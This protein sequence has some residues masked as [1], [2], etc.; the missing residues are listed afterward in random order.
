MPAVL[1]N[2][3]TTATLNIITWYCVFAVFRRGTCVEKVAYMPKDINMVVPA[4][5]EILQ[6]F[7]ALG[8]AAGRRPEVRAT[9]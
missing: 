8:L 7:N 4:R 5:H 2:C 1:T 9:Q 3:C 6:N